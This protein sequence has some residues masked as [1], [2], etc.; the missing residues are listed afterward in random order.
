[1]S[2]FLEQANIGVKHTS[3]KGDA[4]SIVPFIIDMIEAPPELLKQFDAPVSR[5]NVHHVPVLVRGS[6][7]AFIVKCRN[8]LSILDTILYVE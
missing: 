4:G 5:R 7:I 2:S 3:E 6:P 8:M 1:M